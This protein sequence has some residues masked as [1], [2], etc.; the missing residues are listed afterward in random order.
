MAWFQSKKEGGTI[1]SGD[2]P[3]GNS[4]RQG[5][6]GIGGFFANVATKLITT[7]NEEKE[8][9]MQETEPDTG[10][11]HHARNDTTNNNMVPLWLMLSPAGDASSK[12]IEEARNAIL[13]LT[14]SKRNFLNAPPEDVNFTFDYNARMDMALA[15][16]NADPK[17]NMARFY[18]V[19]TYIKEEEFW[20]NWFYRVQIILTAYGLAMPTQQQQRQPMQQD[21][22]PQ[23]RQQGGTPTIPSPT[24][25]VADSLSTMIEKELGELGIHTPE[26]NPEAWEEELKQE[27]LSLDPAKEGPDSLLSQNWEEELML[28]LGLKNSPKDTPSLDLLA[29]QPPEA[30]HSTDSLTKDLS[31]PVPDTSKLEP[32]HEP[33]VVSPTP[34][35][36]TQ[37]NTAT[38]PP[39]GAP[40]TT[41]PP[42]THMPPYDAIPPADT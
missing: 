35:N 9:F 10:V 38:I 21:E 7:I 19:P 12:Q 13:D 33:L 34:V 26:S 39:F 4:V 8:H 6:N 32:P 25:S 11:G 14:K 24:L 15:A 42:T 22:P 5:L 36:N 30:S 27:L 29:N 16:I 1:K 37:A 40:E 2:V 17:L 3:R 31:P 28:E 41:I 18:L 20:R 23:A